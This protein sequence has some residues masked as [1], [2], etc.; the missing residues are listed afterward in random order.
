MTFETRVKLGR[1]GLEVSRLG[2]A[3]GYGVPAG[4]IEKAFHEHGLNYFYPS[5]LKRRQ[6]KTRF[7]LALGEKPWPR[8][9]SW[10]SRPPPTKC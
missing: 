7:H 5:L 8:P 10:R 1:T 9:S 6:R 3:S 2:I 4:A